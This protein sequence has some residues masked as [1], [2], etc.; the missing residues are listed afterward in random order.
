M[1]ASTTVSVSKSPSYGKE[2]LRDKNLELERRKER[3]CDEFIDNF[4]YHFERRK[5]DL[6]EHLLRKIH[7]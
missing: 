3:V 2:R 7:T 6:H 1:E 4:D 5:K